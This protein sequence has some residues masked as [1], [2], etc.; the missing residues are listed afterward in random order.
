MSDSNIAKFLLSA[1]NAL[2][3][4]YVIYRRPRRYVR[5]I[6]NDT[7]LIPSES[8]VK[9]SLMKAD[10]YALSCIISS[11]YSLNE[12]RRKNEI[13][14]LNLWGGKK[15]RGLVAASFIL[16]VVVEFIACCL[17]GGGYVF[18]SIPFSV[19]LALVAGRLFPRGEYREPVVKPGKIDADSGAPAVL[20]KSL[21]K[22]KSR[23]C[24]FVNIR[25]EIADLRKAELWEFY[26]RIC[27]YA[28]VVILFVCVYFDYVGSL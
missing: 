14:L 27:S 18:A 24:D 21:Q 25:S 8:E 26:F 4:S 1:A 15:E 23:I 3:A 2:A 13:A 9:Y 11:L 28:S 19:A 22:E 16:P 10:D 17:F 7:P 20:V 5:C 12:T 6:E